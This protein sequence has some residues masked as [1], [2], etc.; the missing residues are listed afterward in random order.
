MSEPQSGTSGSEQH[1]DA[2]ARPIDAIADRY[3]DD[4]IALQPELATLLGVPGHDDRWS[5]YSPEGHAA[6]ADLDRRTVAAL[7]AAAPTD[8]RENTA[9]EAMLERLG[10]AGELYDARISTSRVS[11]I[12]GAAQEIR[13]IF[14]LMPTDSAEAW[15]H[16]ATRL[17]E[18][19]TPLGQVRETLAAEAQDGN[20]SAVRQI[21]GT[22]EQIRSWTGQSGSDDFFAGLVDGLPAEY[23]D[24]VGAE[25]REAA[26]TAR[27]AFATSAAG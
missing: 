10:L 13:S 7:V 2:A 11:V 4:L 14:D 26:D 21:N 1:T 27:T 18:I 23:A 9:K 24:E 8:E 17:R 6:L 19:G 15:H 20:V 16:V 12:A 5:D 25:L 22:V 3:V